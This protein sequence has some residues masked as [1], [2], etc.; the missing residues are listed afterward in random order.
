MENKVMV[1][2]ERRP[3]IFS[4]RERGDYLRGRVQGF[5]RVEVKGK[6]LEAVIIE[7]D[8]GR[9]WSTLLS[10]GLKPLKEMIGEKV[11]IWFQGFAKL[12]NG[13]YYKKFEILRLAEAGIF[14]NLI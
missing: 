9:V 6:E 5:Q 11:E 12:E 7:D 3:S 10:S 13:F 14:K 2:T 4:F 1:E 8:N